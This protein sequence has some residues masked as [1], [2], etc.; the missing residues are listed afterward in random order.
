MLNYSI[1]LNKAVVLHPVNLRWVFRNDFEIN[2]EDLMFEFT[3]KSFLVELEPSAVNRNIIWAIVMGEV[4]VS[5]DFR[6]H[7]S[8]VL[9]AATFKISY[10]D[11]AVPDIAFDVELNVILM[12]VVYTHVVL[13]AVVDPPGKF[14]DDG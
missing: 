12:V 13:L 5:H 3:I 8:L 7:G 6:F 9:T 4:W 2:P 14:V 1:S 10:P 11:E